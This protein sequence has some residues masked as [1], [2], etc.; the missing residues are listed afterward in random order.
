MWDNYR[1]SIQAGI[2]HSLHR[3]RMNLDGALEDN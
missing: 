2:D 1:L 3:A